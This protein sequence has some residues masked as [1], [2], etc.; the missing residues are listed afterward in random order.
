MIIYNGPQ[1][2]SQVHCK[3]INHHPSMCLNEGWVTKCYTFILLKILII[4]HYL[5]FSPLPLGAWNFSSQKSSSPFLAWA[6]TPCKEHPFIMESTPKLCGHLFWFFD[7]AFHSSKVPFP[8]GPITHYFL[9]NACWV[10]F[11]WA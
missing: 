9:K 5:S 7:S 1:I 10:R 4:L 8:C 6:N 3:I 2:H 11:S